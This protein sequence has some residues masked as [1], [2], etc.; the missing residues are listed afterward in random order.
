MKVWGAS[1]DFDDLIDQMKEKIKF[2]LC[3]ELG[4]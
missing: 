1:Y 4:D 2:W 3:K